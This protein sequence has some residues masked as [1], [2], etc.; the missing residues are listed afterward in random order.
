MPDCHIQR[1]RKDSYGNHYPNP[2]PRAGPDR[3]SCSECHRPAGRGQHHPLYRPL[4]EGTPR[5]HGRHRS[6]HAGG[7]PAISAEPGKTPGGSQECG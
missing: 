7:P 6:A 4:P 1:I 5:L 3:S 2:G